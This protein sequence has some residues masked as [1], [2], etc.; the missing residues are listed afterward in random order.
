M[1]CYITV[2]LP[3]LLCLHQCLKCASTVRYCHVY[4]YNTLTWYEQTD[5]CGISQSSLNT[6][7]QTWAVLLQV[8]LGISTA[9][10]I[11]IE[12]DL[13]HLFLR[14]L[15]SCRKNKWC[16]FS[17]H[18]ISIA[19][20]SVLPH[21]M[22]SSHQSIHENNYVSLQLTIMQLKVQNTQLKL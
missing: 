14:Q 20:L 21:V 11:K 3:W 12:Q 2:I 22:I 13:H 10:I 5:V 18:C 1:C 19:P 7:Q 15:W 4:A 16:N 17:L 6:H 9:K 8:H